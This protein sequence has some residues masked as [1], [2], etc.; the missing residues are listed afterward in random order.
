M[1]GEEAPKFV[2]Q[3]RE[4]FPEKADSELS[5]KDASWK[6]AKFGRSSLGEVV[7]FKVMEA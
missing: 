3:N 2:W 4:C 5:L 7:S 1:N 6:I